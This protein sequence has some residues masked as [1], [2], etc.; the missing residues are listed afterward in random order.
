MSRR[1]TLGEATP[2]AKNDVKGARWPDL[3]P[4][5]P[6]QAVDAGRETLRLGHV[7]RGQDKRHTLTMSTSTHLRYLSHRS[8]VAWASA[9]VLAY[10]VVGA[11][12]T[13]VTTAPAKS[14]YGLDYVGAA[15]LLAVASKQLHELLRRAATTLEIEGSQLHWRSLLNQGTVDLLT[16]G[17]PLRPSARD[18]DFP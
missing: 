2:A 17:R 16:V 1:R 8:C 4:S 15:L 5:S 18:I 3:Y 7:P 6:A 11:V 12:F 13:F 14:H 9:A 10:F